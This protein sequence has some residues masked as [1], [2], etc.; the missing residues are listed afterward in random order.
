V[1]GS[2]VLSFRLTFLSEANIQRAAQLSCLQ[3]PALAVFLQMLPSPWAQYDGKSQT[4][5]MR[6][7]SDKINPTSADPCAA[8]IGYS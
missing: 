6:Q 8:N 4:G 5:E 2:G 3:L 1:S 7:L